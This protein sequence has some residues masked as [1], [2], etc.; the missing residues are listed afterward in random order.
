MEVD[1][2]RSQ[3]REAE[4]GAGTV[5]QHLTEGIAGYRDA[6]AVECRKAR[7]AGDDTALRAGLGNLIRANEAALAWWNYALRRVSGR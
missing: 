6:A 3:V 2:A 7:R 4:A 5:P 1:R